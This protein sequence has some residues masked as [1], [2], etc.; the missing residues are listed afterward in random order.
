VLAM[1][2]HVLGH[3]AQQRRVAFAAR[4]RVFH[5]RAAQMSTARQCVVTY[6]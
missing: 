1:V 5:Q 4:G 6:R 2:E 3:L